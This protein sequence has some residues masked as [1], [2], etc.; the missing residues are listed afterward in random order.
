M[1]LRTNTEAD[2]QTLRRLNVLAG[3]LHAV[4]LT[5]VLAND[6]SLPVTSTYTPD[7]PGKGFTAPVLLFN[8]RVAYAVAALFGLSAVF[9]FIVAS[10]KFFRRYTA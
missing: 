5:P 7:G 2:A 8:I 10:P 6:F 9:H 4:S 1:H 3:L